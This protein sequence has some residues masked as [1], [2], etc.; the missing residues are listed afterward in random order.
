MLRVAKL[1]SP[2]SVLIHTDDLLE[3]TLKT[4]SSPIYFKESA[5]LHMKLI[6]CFA[7]ATDNR[8][9]QCKGK[10]VIQQLQME[11][12]MFVAQ[13]KYQVLAESKD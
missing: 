9:S 6:L 7:L 8:I 13:R 3:S 4:A 2:S 10:E 11:S 5:A 12:Q 1:L